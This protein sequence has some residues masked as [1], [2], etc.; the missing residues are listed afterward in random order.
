MVIETKSNSKE[1][2]ALTLSSSEEKVILCYIAYAYVASE[3]QALLCIQ[4]HALIQNLVAKF[5]YF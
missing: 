4:T 2:S 3:D 1:N 5:F